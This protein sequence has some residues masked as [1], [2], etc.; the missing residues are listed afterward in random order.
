MIQFGAESM[1]QSTDSTIEND[2]FD[3]ILARSEGK[4]KVLQ[5]KYKD[6]GL[7]DLAQFTSAQQGGFNAYHWEGENF[8]QK[9]GG[10]EWLGPSKRERTG[11]YDTLTFNGRG[12]GNVGGTASTRKE[13]APKPRAVALNDWQFYP[14]RLNILH[15]QEKYAFWVSLW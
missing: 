14:A 9:A 5:L 15:E 7:D 12:G 10:R 1:F 4:S 13:R 3:A 8:Q 11:K 2:D 6:M